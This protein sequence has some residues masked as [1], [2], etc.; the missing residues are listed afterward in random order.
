MVR[1]RD[2][3]FAASP[4][5]KTTHEDP[6]RAPLSIPL[7]YQDTDGFISPVFFCRAGHHG[8]R[9]LSRLSHRATPAHQHRNQHDEFPRA[10]GG[11]GVRGAGGDWT[12]RGMGFPLISTRA[13]D[14]PL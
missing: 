12:A 4:V 6:L 10:A 14:Y 9:G 1:K 7:V 3:A 13:D 2:A 8:H 5:A 11:A